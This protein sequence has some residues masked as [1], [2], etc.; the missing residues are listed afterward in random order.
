MK[1][2][3]VDIFCG[4]GGL[5]HGLKLEG[6]K[7]VAGLDSDAS[8]KFAYEHNNGSTFLHKK[9][10]DAD[11]KALR[12]LYPKGHTKILVG[13]APCQTYSSYSSSRPESEKL[14]D[15]KWKLLTSFADLVDAIDPDIV[16]MENVLRL[17]TFKGGAIFNEFIARLEK[18]YYVSFF[19]VYCPDYG[20]PQ[21]RRR[22]VLFA[23]KYGRVEITPKT[24]KPGQ[25]KTVEQAIKGLPPLAD[26]QAHAT[27]PLHRARALS[28]INR[29]RMKAAIPGGSWRDWADELIADCHKR[30][31]GAT[32]A[33]V[34][35]RMKW[36]EP[37]PTI[38]TLCYS[39]GS[40]RFGHPEQH[41]ALSL[42][43][44]AI[45][46]T[47]PENYKFVE[48]GGSYALN[49]LGRHIGNAVPVD[50]GRVIAKSINQHLEKYNGR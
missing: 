14:K 34:Y 32:Y 31:T 36:D 20:M 23:S 25:Y 45:L 38:T 49:A 3:V 42:R 12:A 11:P 30:D 13:C 16:S 17:R 44:A 2:A 39:F 9:I 47:F 7:V 29:R 35:G 15:D 27:D 8:C 4:V 21:H 46:Q 28:D 40:G 6:M 26:G 48:P 19:N 41:R 10:E 33:S 43:E 18:S 22:L 50:L 37:S 1:S 24:H 5:T